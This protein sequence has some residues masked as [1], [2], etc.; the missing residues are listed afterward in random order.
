MRLWAPIEAVLV[1][2]IPAQSGTT[3]LQ[4]D[5]LSRCCLVVDAAGVVDAQIISVARFGACSSK[6]GPKNRGTFKRRWPFEVNNRVTAVS[7]KSNN[8]MFFTHDRL[9]WSSDK[10]NLIRRRKISTLPPSN[11]CKYC[12]QHNRL[13]VLQFLDFIRDEIRENEKG[14]F[15]FLSTVLGRCSDSHDATIT[16]GS[17]PRHFPAHSFP[18]PITVV[19]LQIDYH[20]S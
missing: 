20:I 10:E 16:R 15:S 9:A 8:D 1:R 5:G 11:A 4:V 19:S 13:R 2:W 6:W 18:W 3:I 14:P 12:T 7:S 17:C